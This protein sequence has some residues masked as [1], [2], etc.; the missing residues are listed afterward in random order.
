MNNTFGNHLRLTLFGESHGKCV[1]AVLDG[2][3]A[4]IEI[5]EDIIEKALAARRP[6]GDISTARRESD[7][8]EI[9]SGSFRGYTDGS[10]LCMIIPNSDTKS[11]DYERFSGLLRPGHADFTSH[12]KNA[13]YE[14]FRGGGHFS[15]RMTAA[16]VAVCSVVGA[17]LEAKGIY[18]GTH[19]LSVGNISDRAIEDSDD[20]ASAVKS[21]SFDP[22]PV[23]DKDA[24]EKMR[25]LISSARAD[26]DS[27]GGVLECAV[28]GLPAG[29]GDPWFDTAE[30]M[31]S[32][33]LF[34]IPAV[35]GIE[36]GGG[37]ALTKMR[38]SEANDAFELKDGRITTTT[39]NCGGILGGISTGGTISFRLAVNS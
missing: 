33:A 3:P 4:G 14:D 22:F 15:G 26:G 30:G 23:L 6:A 25:A 37:F 7:R 1:G 34:S 12:I 17:A 36:F 20:I 24:G 19:I 8:F 13:G 10:P 35:K 2:L 18:I 5:K 32:H 9:V 16:I 38:G 39:N 21:L 31:L 11:E 27:V 29:L 28:C